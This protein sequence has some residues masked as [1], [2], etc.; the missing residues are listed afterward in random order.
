M[1]EQKTIPRLLFTLMLF[2]AVALTGCGEDSSPTAVTDP[3][4]K[5]AT[6]DIPRPAPPAARA[7]RPTVALV[8]TRLVNRDTPDRPAP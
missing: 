4:G 2:A 1:R 6:A 7:A 5:P 8:D 3:H